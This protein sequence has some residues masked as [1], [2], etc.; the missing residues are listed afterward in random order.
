MDFE[1][2]VSPVIQSARNKYDSNL[3]FTKKFLQVFFK[4]AIVRLLDARSAT[5][6]CFIFFILASSLLTSSLSPTVRS[7]LQPIA[8]VLSRLNSF[9][10]FIGVHTSGNRS[11]FSKSEWI[12]WF[13]NVFALPLHFSSCL[14]LIG[15]IIVAL[16]IFLFLMAHMEHARGRS[17]QIWAL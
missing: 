13:L 17:S 11:Y 12:S 2:R 15:A 9:S 3:I 16:L 8:V 1:I 10:W 7:W 5:D 4:N 14:K 6:S